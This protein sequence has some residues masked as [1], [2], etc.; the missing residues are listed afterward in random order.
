MPHRRSR[1]G[2]LITAALALAGACLMLTACAAFSGESQASAAQTQIDQSRQIVAAERAAQ[3]AKLAAAQAGSEAA[4]RAQENLAK[5][6]TMEHR[7]A[8]TEE[9]LQKA[10]DPK[11][12]QVTMA[13]A[14][15]G[16]AT[17]LPFPFNLIAQVAGGMLF[18]AAVRQPAVTGAR[19]A[20]A[21]L[22]DMVLHLDDATPETDTTLKD[23]ATKLLTSSARALVNNAIADR[24][25]AAA[26]I[27]S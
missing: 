15:Q 4:T 8:Q 25:K 19:T 22:A 14:A 24:A 18:G 27:G 11:T 6:A 16:A 1:T 20:A 5:I 23:G 10:T 13:G 26:G 17:F 2:H 12:G 3:E 21:S 7:L 9:L